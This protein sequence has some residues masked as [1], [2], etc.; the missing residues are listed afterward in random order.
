MELLPKHQPI[1]EKNAVVQLGIIA[2]DL[3]RNKWLGDM[4]WLLW[5]LKHFTANEAY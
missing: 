5:G 3:N 1:G 4:I 2:R